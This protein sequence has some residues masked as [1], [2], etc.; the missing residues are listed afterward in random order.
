MYWPPTAA[1]GASLEELIGAD[2]ARTHG[3]ETPAGLFGYPP[4]SDPWSHWLHAEYGGRTAIRQ[5]SNI[6]WSNGLLDPWSAAGLATPAFFW[7]RETESETH[8]FE[9]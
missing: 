7:G 8:A 9:F 2:G 1:R 4:T 6:V 3:C 5:T